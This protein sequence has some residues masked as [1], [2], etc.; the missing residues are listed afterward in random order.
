MTEGDSLDSQWIA[1]IPMTRIQKLKRVPL[2]AYTQWSHEHCYLMHPLIRAGQDET[3]A[4]LFHR[5]IASARGVPKTVL[6]RGLA[7]ES[8]FTQ[9]IEKR[10]VGVESYDRGYLN[11]SGSLDEHYQRMASG[12]QHR[13]LE[14]KKRRLAEA[15]KL[16]CHVNDHEA[17]LESWTAEFMELEGS[18]WKGRNG[19]ALKCKVSDADF[20]RESFARAHAAGR[21]LTT[22]MRLDGRMIA[23]TVDFEG[24]GGVFC[25][26]IAFD[27]TF[28]K[29]SPGLL[30]EIE[31]IRAIY[32]QSNLYWADS[33]MAPKSGASRNFWL[34]SRRVVSAAVSERAFPDRVISKFAYA[35]AHLSRKLKDSRRQTKK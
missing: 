5:W 26:K 8:P 31:H 21:L 3:V 4:G 18:G 1:F 17:G 34:E 29:Y 16:A 6:W 24:N 7:G 25:F 19:T 28:G 20:T 32:A 9:C 27:E 13:E 10:A 22:C 12:S 35:C 2:R 14:R 23:A 30:L 15:G 33:C 11:K